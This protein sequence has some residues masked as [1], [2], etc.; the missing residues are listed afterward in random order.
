MILDLS[1]RLPKN[2]FWKA[3]EVDGVT[4]PSKTVNHVKNSFVLDIA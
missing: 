4:F 1:A 3:F 2:F